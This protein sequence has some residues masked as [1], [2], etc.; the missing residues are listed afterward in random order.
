MI[1]H[2][3]QKMQF[4]RNLLLD[5]KLNKQQTKYIISLL[6]SNLDLCTGL[7]CERCQLFFE[8][9]LCEMFYKSDFFEKNRNL[10][11]EYTTLSKLQR[12]YTK[13]LV[14]FLKDNN[15]TSQK[16]CNDC[17]LSINNILCSCNRSTG[18]EPFTKED[19]Q[20]IFEIILGDRK[21]N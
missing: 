19:R 1:N 2:Q 18:F 12:K 17:I 16:E 8:K 15:C 10:Q 20:K 9:K 11:R 13:Q 21:L 6:Q 5:K 14:C 4:L 7:S 3:T